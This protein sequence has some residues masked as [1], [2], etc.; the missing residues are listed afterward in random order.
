MR[1]LFAFS[2]ILT[3]ITSC[4]KDIKEN[5]PDNGCIFPAITF[6]PPYSDPVWHPSGQLFGFNYTPL[7]GIET[8]GTAPCILL[9]LFW[10]TGFY[11]VLF[12]E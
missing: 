2:F 6:L 11:R 4:K 10:Q 1:Y 7:T 3:L 8:N 5:T 9:Q 12:D